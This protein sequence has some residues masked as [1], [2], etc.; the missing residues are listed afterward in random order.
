M[1]EAFSVYS[2]MGAEGIVGFFLGWS[3]SVLVFCQQPFSLFSSLWENPV[4]TVRSVGSLVVS[5][6]GCCR[7]EETQR[8]KVLN[9]SL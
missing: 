4:M 1:H 9:D 2:S 7:G 6:T 8:V 5:S 3:S